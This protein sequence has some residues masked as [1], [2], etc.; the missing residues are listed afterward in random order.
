MEIDIHKIIPRIRLKR[1]EVPVRLR[2][3]EEEM[4]EE[5]ERLLKQKNLMEAF[6]VDTQEAEKANEILKRNQ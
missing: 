2:P 1:I 4:K 5:I 6:T 3:T